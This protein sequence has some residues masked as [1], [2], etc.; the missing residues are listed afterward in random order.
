[1]P[2]AGCPS[3]PA[4]RQTCSSGRSS[5]RPATMCSPAAPAGRASHH[6]PKVTSK[7]SHRM[8]DFRIDARQSSTHSSG[9]E[10]QTAA[11][12]HVASPCRGPVIPYRGNAQVGGGSIDGSGCSYASRRVFASSAIRGGTVIP[13]EYSCGIGCGRGRA[14]CPRPPGAA[15]GACPAAPA[16]RDPPAGC[17]NGRSAAG[18]RVPAAAPKARPFPPR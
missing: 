12:H 7:P 15:C 11:R 6:R 8:R 18:C 1:V 5:G 13:E 4:S 16:R 3:R 17:G 14:A 10:T 9:G 2:V